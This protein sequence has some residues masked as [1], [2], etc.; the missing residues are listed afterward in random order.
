[1]SVLKV[2]SV[3]QLLGI[4][5]YSSLY[6]QLG[7]RDVSVYVLTIFVSILKYGPIW[8]DLISILEIS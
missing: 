5:F 6:V 3:V 4:V 8:F 1:M 2:S 7:L